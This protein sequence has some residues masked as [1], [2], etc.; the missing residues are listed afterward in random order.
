ME[1]IIR[2]YWITD[3]VC[4]SSSCLQ[5][6]ACSSLQA[7]PLCRRLV[8]HGF[9]VAFWVYVTLILGGSGSRISSLGVREDHPRQH[10]RYPHTLILRPRDMRNVNTIF[11]S[12]FCPVC[13]NVATRN[14]FA[15]KRNACLSTSLDDE[16]EKSCLLD[17]LAV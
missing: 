13:R 4:W 10:N 16:R 17:T 12:L 8:G 15:L 6:R 11:M 2:Q 9:R 5:R 3:I 14:A 1:Q 7:I